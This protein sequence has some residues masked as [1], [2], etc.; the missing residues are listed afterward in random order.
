VASSGSSV[1]IGYYM[2][3]MA[4]VSAISVSFMKQA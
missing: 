3:A 2:A 1:A 4:A